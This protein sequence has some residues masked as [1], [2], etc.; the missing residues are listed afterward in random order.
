[1]VEVSGEG[2]GVLKATIGR[3][4]YSCASFLLLL[5]LFGLLRKSIKRTTLSFLFPCPRM[6]SV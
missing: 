2:E 3:S 6:A 1:M 4:I 5:L